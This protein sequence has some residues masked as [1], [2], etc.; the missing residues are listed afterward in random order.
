MA[1][2]TGCKITGKVGTTYTLTAAANGFTT[3]TSNAFSITF[4]A[5]SQLVFTTQPGAGPTVPP[6]DPSPR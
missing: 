3:V 6:V 1:S 4:G 2:A 5:A